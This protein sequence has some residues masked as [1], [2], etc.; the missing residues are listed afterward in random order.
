[1][2]IVKNIEHINKILTAYLW[3]TH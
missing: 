3:A 1:M 2:G